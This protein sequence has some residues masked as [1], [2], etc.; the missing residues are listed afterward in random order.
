M[1]KVIIS[2]TYTNDYFLYRTSN[3]GYTLAQ[4]IGNDAED[5]CFNDKSKYTILD[6]HSLIDHDY[7]LFYKLDDFYFP[8]MN[9]TNFSKAVIT[10]DGILFFCCGASLIVYDLLKHNDTSFNSISSSTV[11]FGLIGLNSDGKPR[12]LSSHHIFNIQDGKIIPDIILQNSS[13]TIFYVD[14]VS[15]PNYDTVIYDDGD[16]TYFRKTGSGDISID[17]VN[18]LKTT[19]LSWRILN[20]TPTVKVKPISGGTFTTIQHNGDSTGLVDV[21][22]RLMSVAFTGSGIIEIWG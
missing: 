18:V 20:G 6:K 10:N 14:C 19:R 1:E 9:Y 21:A 12:L 17:Y 15:I 8:E 16:S 5:P 11:G 3:G 13:E 22:D 4:S 2:G 7:K